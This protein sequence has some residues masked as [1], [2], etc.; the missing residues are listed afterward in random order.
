MSQTGDAWR[1]VI[2]RASV[3]TTA[4]LTRD[5]TALRPDRVVTDW[6]SGVGDLARADVSDT[7]TTT[8]TNTI[9]WFIDLMLEGGFGVDMRAAVL[10]HDRPDLAM[11]LFTAGPE[12]A[13][14]LMLDGIAEREAMQRGLNR[15]AL[16][17]SNYLDSV[18][19][20]ELQRVMGD[21]YVTLQGYRRE[22]K[23]GAC[24]FCRTLA[25]RTNPALTG[26]VIFNVTEQ[27]AKPHPGCK[28][29]LL[30]QPIY[31][32]RRTLRPVELAQVREVKRELIAERDAALKALRERHPVAA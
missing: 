13:A 31:K 12:Y 1:R 11:T 27:W 21:N 10:L 7:A 14:T 19:K 24:G 2:R 9:L 6:L 5:W 17:S 3:L 32:V 25:A 26:S 29:V 4:V 18:S 20:D 30:P 16:A 28:C 8:R 23:P 22:A 15:L